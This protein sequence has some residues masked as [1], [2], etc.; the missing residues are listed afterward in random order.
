MT[1]VIPKEK[2]IIIRSWSDHKLIKMVGHEISCM[3]KL[4]IKHKNT[5][6]DFNLAYSVYTQFGN[7]AWNKDKNVIF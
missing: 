7:L 6:H 2:V 1:F 4:K 5:H 3:H